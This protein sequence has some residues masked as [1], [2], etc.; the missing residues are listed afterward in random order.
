M[1][2]DVVGTDEYACN[3]YRALFEG[4]MNDVG[5]AVLIEKA[6]MV[7][8][9]E[10]PLFIFS[11]RLMNEPTNRTVSDAADMRQEGKDTHISISDE[12]YA[13]EIISALWKNY[14]RDRVE[15]QTRFD[16]IV[17]GGDMGEI[18]GYR[19]SSG[20]EAMKEIIGALWRV[21]PEGI[22]NRH[23]ITEGN[24]VTIVAT[25][26]IMQPEMIEEGMKVHKS[27]TGGI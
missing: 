7:L 17:Y 15:Q 4:I 25:E 14:G 20:E 21:M 12:R 10:I 27:M 22:K 6:S 26:E 19:I 2:I 9:P 1:Q 24:V 18:A 5:K 16:L 13:P 3:S 8:K 11:V 23:N